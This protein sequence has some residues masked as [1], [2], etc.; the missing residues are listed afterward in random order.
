MHCAMCV[1]SSGGEVSSRHHICGFGVLGLKPPFM[2]ESCSSDQQ[3]RGIPSV[4]C[5]TL[6]LHTH[7][8]YAL[9]SML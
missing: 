1:F 4:I 2:K 9:A 6:F 8:I 7:H 5:N 3:I